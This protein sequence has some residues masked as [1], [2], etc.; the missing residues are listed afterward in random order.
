MAHRT[1]NPSWPR[2]TLSGKLDT[3]AAGAVDAALLGA[4]LFELEGPMVRNP[5]GLM[6]T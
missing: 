5:A 1:T 2:V 3:S 6:P 4:T